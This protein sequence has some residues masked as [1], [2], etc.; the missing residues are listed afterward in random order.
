MPLPRRR[1]TKALLEQVHQ[2]RH[3]VLFGPGSPECRHLLLPPLGR[4]TVTPLPWGTGW[5]YWGCGWW[6]ALGFGRAAGFGSPIGQHGFMRHKNDP[7]VDHLA[8]LLF[9]KAVFLQ[10]LPHVAG[11]PRAFFGVPKLGHHLN[12]PSLL[13]LP[14][15]VPVLE[16]LLLG[17]LRD[18][19]DFGLNTGHPTA[20]RIAL[21]GQANVFSRLL[22][23]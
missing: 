7:V 2:E 6:R 20:Q 3:R 13:N 14:Q 9:A 4:S 10:P 22:C 23:R 12:Q 15:L 18:T 21:R 19:L 16:L 1:F 17:L 8:D 5:L 11:K